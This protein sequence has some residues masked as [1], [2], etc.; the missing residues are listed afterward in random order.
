MKKKMMYVGR[1]IITGGKKFPI[2]KGKC[3]PLRVGSFLI[4]FKGKSIELRVVI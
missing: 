3:N 1:T 2:K 4:R